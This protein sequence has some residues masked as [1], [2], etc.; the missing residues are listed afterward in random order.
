[1]VN[2]IFAYKIARFAPKILARF[3]ELAEGC[4]NFF[5]QGVIA[6]YRTPDV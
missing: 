2:S 5:G 1:M 6:A 3:Y 4:P